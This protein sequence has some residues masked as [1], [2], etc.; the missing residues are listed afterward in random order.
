MINTTANKKNHKHHEQITN[1][2]ISEEPGIIPIT[3]MQ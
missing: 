1:N 3:T 2:P